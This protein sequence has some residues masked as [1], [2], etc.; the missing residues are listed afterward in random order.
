MNRPAKVDTSLINERDREC[1][2][3]VWEDLGG[4]L[5]IWVREIGGF[6]ARVKA[7]GSLL[8]TIVDGIDLSGSMQVLICRL[9]DRPLCP[10][11]FSGFYHETQILSWIYFG[12]IASFCANSLPLC[13]AASEIVIER[14][15][16]R[17]RSRDRSVKVSGMGGRSDRRRD[18]D[19]GRGRGR[20]REGDR[21]RVIERGRGMSGDPIA[22]AAHPRFH[23]WEM[24]D[25]HRKA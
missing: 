6:Y 22:I 16:R 14:G 12:E 23:E 18:R 24:G 9:I 25:S 3:E 2:R 4:I 10:T 5:G 15:K 8:C 19:R 1:P 7:N 11:M 17:W 20:G 21:D 13:H